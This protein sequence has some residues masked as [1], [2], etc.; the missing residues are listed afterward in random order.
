M[1]KIIVVVFI[2]IIIGGLIGY[3]IVN[4]GT[5]AAEK[6]VEEIQ[7]EEGVPV[8]VAKSFVS[9][10]VVSNRYTG[11]VEGMSQADIISEIGE[12]IKSVLKRPGSKV[13]KGETL[14][15]FY[16]TSANNMMLRLD[17]VELLLND[18]K[19]DYERVKKLHDVGAV[20]PQD[21]DKA[22]LNYDIAKQNYN[23]AK[24]SV[25]VKAPVSGIITKI[26]FEAGETP[27]RGDVLAQ[28]AKIEKVKIKFPVSE[29]EIQKIKTG[30]IAS[31]KVDTYPA[32]QFE[33]IIKEINMAADPVSRNFEVMLEMDNPDYLL[34]PGMFA[35]IDVTV[36]KKEGVIVVPND[37]VVEENGNEYVWTVSNN[38]TARKQVQT[39]LKNKNEIEVLS[40]IGSDETVVVL[41]QNNI[42]KD[43]QKVIIIE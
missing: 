37:A 36:E 20:S 27:G 6:S 7:M 1:K 12:K 13:K 4:L 16:K 30:Q 15:E 5:G 41:G 8:E 3:R 9:D 19:R 22:K 34:K 26:E 28:V 2:I 42:Q 25:Y 32:K 29:V 21:L 10:M 17:Q 14:I 38:V 23:S 40:G 31:V 11:T 35:R 39:G 18:A 33:G 43:N 24:E